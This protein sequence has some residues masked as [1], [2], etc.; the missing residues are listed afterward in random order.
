M[1]SRLIACV[2]AICALPA[3]RAAG[4]PALV[5]LE[6]GSSRVGFYDLQGNLLKEVETGL[7]PH[8]GIFSADGR[9]LFT[10]DNGVMDMHETGKGWNTVSI[11]DVKAE[12]RVGVVD[13]GE[14]RRPHGI[15][16]DPATGHVLVTTELPSALLTVDPNTRKVLRVYDVKG[17]APHMVRI[18][19]NHK[20]AWVSCTESAHITAVDLDT[21]ATKVLA[22]GP[23]PQG[24]AFSPD[25]KRL[26]VA[27]S[28]GET[29]TVIDPVKEEVA[30]DIPIGGKH[31]TPNRVVVLPDGKTLMAS[32]QTEHAVG[33]A[34]AATRKPGKV[35][36]VSGE[37]VSINL[38]PD[39]KLAYSAV[40]V[41]DT[42]F[43]ISVPEQRVL[44]SFKTPPG[45]GPDPV[46]SIPK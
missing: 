19:P 20:T 38:S 6:K 46:L 36:K 41:Q 13:L 26:Y 30:G 10:S 9:Y 31:S 33:Y 39:A 11:I 27:N 22:T 1:T 21:G 4:P 16:F 17:K 44:R 8:E 35:L 23:R 32:L 25:G 43:V 2:L 12:R 42:I 28:D 3:L 40:L 24:I 45:S 34:D 37:T 29:I 7:H 18:A 5:I 15:D 14:H